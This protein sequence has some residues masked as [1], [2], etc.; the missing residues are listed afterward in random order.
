[1]VAKQSVMFWKKGTKTLW[2]GWW[3][4]GSPCSKRF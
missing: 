1:M 4:Q 3:V 2:F